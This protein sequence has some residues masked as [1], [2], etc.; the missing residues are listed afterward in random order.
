MGQPISRT[1]LSEKAM[2]FNEKLGGNSEFKVI[3]LHNFK[4]RHGI[5][6]LEIHRK[7]LSTNNE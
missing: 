4:S 1:I 3:C 5:W 6:E 2:L 7:K